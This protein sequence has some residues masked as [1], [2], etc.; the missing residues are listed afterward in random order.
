M[1][2]ARFINDVFFSNCSGRSNSKQVT[3][4]YCL[5]IQNA[6]VSNP[7]PK[8][9]NWTGSSGNWSIKELTTMRTAFIRIKWTGRQ[10]ASRSHRTYAYWVRDHVSCP[11][12][13]IWWTHPRYILQRQQTCEGVFNRTRPVPFA[14]KHV[15]T[16]VYCISLVHYAHIKQVLV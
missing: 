6:M 4:L 11:C 7:H 16:R 10:S 14:S 15:I 1:G 3:F 2:S 5:I 8:F 13:S 9:T 12:R